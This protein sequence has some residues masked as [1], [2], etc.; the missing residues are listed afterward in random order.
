MITFRK[1]RIQKIVPP[2]DVRS[3]KGLKV[4]WYMG[5]NVLKEP[6]ASMLVA[7]LATVSHSKAFLLCALRD[8]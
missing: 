3:Y 7:S 4:F 1:E 2:V 8:H 6:A 5:T